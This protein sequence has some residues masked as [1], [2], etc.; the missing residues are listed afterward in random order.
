MEIL[1]NSKPTPCN[2]RKGTPPSRN[3][4]D[5]NLIKRQATCISNHNEV[6]RD[7]L[8]PLLN[9]VDELVSKVNEQDKIIHHLTN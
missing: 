4:G 7:I 5:I 2:K 1:S 8:L 6:Y 9:K 3:S